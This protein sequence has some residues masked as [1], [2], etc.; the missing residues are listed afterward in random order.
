MHMRIMRLTQPQVESATEARSQLARREDELASMRQEL[1]QVMRAQ[2]DA[3]QQAAE[4]RAMLAKRE[5]QLQRAWHDVDERDARLAE[6]EG[7]HGACGHAVEVAVRICGSGVYVG[8]RSSCGREG[9]RSGPD[10]IW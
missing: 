7:A 8:G 6:L 1:E 9:R 10:G 5:V 2:A 4:A 3:E